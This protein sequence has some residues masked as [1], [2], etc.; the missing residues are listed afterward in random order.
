MSHPSDSAIFK[1]FP[2]N[3]MVD[4]M[5]LT[6]FEASN[7]EQGKREYV[8]DIILCLI[9]NVVFMELL[10][11]N[12]NKLERSLKK[13]FNGTSIIGIYSCKKIQ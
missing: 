13:H 7:L 5:L 12:N 3:K 10:L 11:Q 9:K 2:C 8:G 1:L 4:K 6:F